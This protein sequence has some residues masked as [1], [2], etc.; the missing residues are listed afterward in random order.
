MASIGT[1]EVTFFLQRRLYGFL[2][3]SV[4][5]PPDRPGIYTKMNSEKD[6]DCR[7]MVQTC[8]LK[9]FSRTSPSKPDGALNCLLLSRLPHRFGRYSASGRCS[10]P[11]DKRISDAISEQIATLSE[12]VS[13]VVLATKR[14]HASR[15]LIYFAPSVFTLRPVNRKP[16]QIREE[17]TLV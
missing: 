10:A 8:G 17:S 7:R 3:K 11:L 1:F 9:I 14:P 15:H 12:F 5:S 4:N 16:R 6:M 2:N 13:A